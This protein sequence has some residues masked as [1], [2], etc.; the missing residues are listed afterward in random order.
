MPEALTARIPETI[1]FDVAAA[2]MFQG[3]TAHYL[4]HDVAA[5]REGSTCLVQAAS[6]A[7]GQIIV[8][9]AKGLGATVI[10]TANTKAKRDVALGRGA[11]HAIRYDEG[12][13][14]DEVRALTDGRGVD[15]VFDSV[16]LSTH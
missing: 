14:A 8:Q 1:G 13:F 7:I 11:D 5:L 12:G 4:V 9:L 2:A 16:G 10:A 15:V 3:C 6:G